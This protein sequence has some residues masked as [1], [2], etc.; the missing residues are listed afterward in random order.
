VT[1]SGQTTSIANAP[2]VPL[3][4]AGLFTDTGS[5]TLGGQGN[6][7]ATLKFSHG[8]LTVYHYSANPNGTQTGNPTTCAFSGT[9]SGTFKVVSG[10]GSYAGTTGS[11]TFKVTFTGMGPKLSSGACNQS[12]SAAPTSMLTVFRAT[13]TLT[14]K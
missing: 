5:I 1:F 13:G 6:G 4:A 8:N 7:N 3:T 11:G 10:T 14:L 9:S 2:V 12:Q